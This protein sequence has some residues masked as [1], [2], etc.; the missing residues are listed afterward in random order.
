MK[1]MTD[2]VY[3]VALASLLHD[4]GKPLQRACKSDKS[5]LSDDSKGMS[6]LV[7]YQHAL[8][9]A[10]FLFRY[11]NKFTELSPV[12]RYGFENFQK[13]A[14]KHHKPDNDKPDEIIIQHADWKSAGLDRVKDENENETSRDTYI[15]KPLVSLFTRARIENMAA[16]VPCYHT[17]GDLHSESVFPN[18]DLELNTINYKNLVTS[19]EMD[20]QK[21][22][23]KNPIIFLESITSLLV[24]YFWCVPSSTIDGFADIPLA[25]HLITT[26]AIASAM[27]V[28]LEITGKKPSQQSFRLLSGDF[29]GIQNFIFSLSGES[30]RNIAKLLRGR[31]FL[32]NLYNVLAARAVTDMCG[33][34]S[35]N[36]LTTAG[37]KF[38]I[39]LPDTP[40]IIESVAEIKTKIE[41]WT[42]ENFFGEIR[43]IID[44]GVVFN[45]NE[46]DLENFQNVFKRASNSLN[47]SK[48]KPFA[49]ILEKDDLWIDNKRFANFKTFKN[50]KIC[51]KEPSMP[52]GKQVLTVMMPLILGQNCI[53]QNF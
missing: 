17:L 2:I 10:D 32:V 14:S 27:V 31:S 49:Q 5:T 29:A 37:G 24:R 28:N 30:D 12:K 15:K 4:I 11:R 39:L 3:C 8:W 13:L 18:K 19:F 20:F 6:D 26:S 7:G 43:I 41:K 53:N 21:I 45:Y 25:D 33:L 9:T 1:E 40:L 51:G 23:T 50:C 38:Q 52:D 36:A 42:F 44:N 47:L 35:I 34:P 16:G 22:S 48:T 46:F